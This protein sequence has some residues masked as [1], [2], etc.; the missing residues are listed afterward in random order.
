VPAYVAFYKSPPEFV[1]DDVLTIEVK[2]LGGRTEIQKITV[3]VVGQERNR[4]S[5]RGRLRSG[6]EPGITRSVSTDQCWLASG[7]RRF[8]N[9]SSL[10]S[11]VDLLKAIRPWLL[12][13]QHEGS[14]RPNRC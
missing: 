14:A 12:R 7:D 8:S 3:N 9:F 4:R 6:M 11:I 2:Y 5:N 13:M 10:P 1:G